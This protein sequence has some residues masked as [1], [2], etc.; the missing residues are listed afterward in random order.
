MADDDPERPGSRAGFFYSSTVD[1]PV[2]DMNGPMMYGTSIPGFPMV[3]IDRDDAKSI[4]TSYSGNVPAARGAMAK[5]TISKVIRK[6]RG[7]GT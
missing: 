7:E 6:I 1:T 2:T 3:A 5:P 4:R